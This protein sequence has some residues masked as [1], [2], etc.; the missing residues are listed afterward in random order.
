V[1]ALNPR[2]KEARMAVLMMLEVPG[3]TLEQYERANELMGITGD[4]D[5]PEGLVSHVAA[6][7][8]DGIVI[9]DVWESEAALE[10]FFEERAGAALAEAG[11]PQAQPRI[12]QVHNH[13]P[14]GAGTDPGV[15]VYLEIDEL[16]PD[17]Y[18]QMMGAMDA[19]AADGNHPAVSHVAAVTEDGGFLVADVWESPEAFAEFAETQ[20][21]TAGESVGMA[22]IEPRFA[23]VH[24]TMKK[25][26]P[27]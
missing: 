8:E 5:A 2:D 27:A 3:G 15:L 7:T 4:D 11:M 24:N 13:I 22:P 12:A 1:L 17:Q 18:D 6:V 20:V 14:Q 26:A 10:T 19:G 16:T 9:A 23:K 21:A 25:G